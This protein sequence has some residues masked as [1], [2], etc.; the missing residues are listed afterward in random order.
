MHSPDDVQYAMETTRVL[1]EPDRRIDTFGDTRFEFL[2]LSELMDRTGEI[3]IRS[4]DVEAVRPRLVKPDAYSELEL[5]GFDPT[6]KERI[7]RMVE[8]MKSEGKDMAFLNYGFRFARSA[9]SEEIVHDPIEQVRERV[10]EDAR[11]RGN[12]AQA[13]IEGVDDAWEVSV[14]KFAL[15]M[16]MHSIPINRF[17]FQRRGLL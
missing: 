7:E 3:R 14:V 1:L 12:P 8:K 13:V 10:L 2:L 11:Q 4:G 9:V 6:A 15:D 5:E 17:D 16:I